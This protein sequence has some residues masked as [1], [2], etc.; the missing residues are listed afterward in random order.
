M[1]VCCEACRLVRVEAEPSLDTIRAE[2]DE[3]AFETLDCK[4]S[5]RWRRP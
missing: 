5:D 3:T 4:S 2:V 1:E